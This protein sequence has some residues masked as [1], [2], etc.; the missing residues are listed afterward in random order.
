MANHVSH[1]T[2]RGV[3][4]ISNKTYVALYNCSSC[5][6]RLPSENLK[7][8]MRVFFIIHFSLFLLSIFRPKMIPKSFSFDLDH[9]HFCPAFFYHFWAFLCHAIVFEFA[10]V[11]MSVDS[12]ISE[13]TEQMKT[14]PS[15]ISDVRL[16][17]SKI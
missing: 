3:T 6:F 4:F 15:Y 8:L 9:Q 1:N 7:N 17:I 11:T 2:S 10:H 13:C 16:F 5:R 14:D 12:R